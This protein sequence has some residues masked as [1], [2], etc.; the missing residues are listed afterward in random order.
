MTH[1]RTN[2]AGDGP[3]SVVVVLDASY[4]M[5]LADTTGIST[6]DRARDATF[7]VFCSRSPW[8]GP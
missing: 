8:P 3:A 6:F 2:T 1:F 7:S 5:S 4:S